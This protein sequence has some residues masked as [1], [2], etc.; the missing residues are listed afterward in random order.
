MSTP[1]EQAPSVDVPGTQQT[2]TANSTTTQSTNFQQSIVLTPPPPA[3]SGQSQITMDSAQTNNIVLGVWFLLVTIALIVALLYG[4]GNYKGTCNIK[5]GGVLMA[6]FLGPFYF[7]Y[8]GVLK[9]KG[10]YAV[11]LD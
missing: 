10:L 11:A 7:I 2:S 3:P 5:I 6:I 9:H 1:A 8:F 4:F